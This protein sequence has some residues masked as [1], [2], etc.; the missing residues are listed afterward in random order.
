MQTEEMLT[1][2]GE[3]Y[4]RAGI[5]VRPLSKTVGAEVTGVDLTQKLDK[6]TFAAIERAWLEHIL[7]LFR[8]Q[9]LNDDQLVA[10]S[11]RFGELD[12]APVMENGRMFVEGY[13]EVFVISNVIEQGVKKGS[14][15][16]EELAWHTDMAYA[17]EPP[18][19]SCL[20]AVE[21]PADV[22]DTGYLNMY[23]TYDRLSADL[24]ARIEG[25]TIKHESV[26]T[27]D[28]YLRE[29]SGRTLDEMKARGTFDIRKLP[30]P[31]HPI[32]RT[33]PE[34]GE[35]ALFIGRRQNTCIEGLEMA[36]SDELLDEIWAHV[37]R[38]GRRSYHH[39]WQPGDLL[40]WDNRCAMHRRDEFPRSARR[41]M[42]RTQIQGDRPF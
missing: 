36:E 19:A 37:K 26:Y 23:R 22:G 25:R 24:K 4:E 27:L 5:E 6:P 28:G 15:G 35:K 33:H 7:L 9:S 34:T 41:I 40:I 12:N 39:R 8:G 21:V 20:Y 10:F 16:A 31:R 17:E 3:V 18:K 29:G 11:K 1:P 32:V 30:G 13:P 38:L 2:A 14:L 42:H